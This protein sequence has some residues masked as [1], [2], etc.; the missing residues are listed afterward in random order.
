MFV[1]EQDDLIVRSES[2]EE[3]DP[4]LRQY[5]PSDLKIASEFL[6]NWLSFLSRDLCKDCV[7][8]LSDRIRSLDP[9]K[10]SNE[11]T[12]LFLGKLKLSVEETEIFFIPV[13]DSAI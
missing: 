9:G 6:T 12:S 7:H 5:E 3:E 13:L 2:M 4:F 10:D 11:K 8:L 1:R